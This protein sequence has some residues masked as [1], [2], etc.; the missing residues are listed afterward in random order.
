MIGSFRL[1]QS[2]TCLWIFLVLFLVVLVSTKALAQIP[3]TQ[4]LQAVL[5]SPDGALIAYSTGEDVCNPPVPASVFIVNAAT[6]NIVKT[7]P[8]GD[9]SILDLAWS[10]DSTRLAGASGDGLGFR[11]WDVDTGLMT[12]I[13]PSGGQG[14]LS[15]DWS[16]SSD[17]I[18]VTGLGGAGNLYNAITGEFIKALRVP[19]TNADWSPDG[20][21]I[22]SVRYSMNSVYVTDVE[23]DSLQMTLEGH[24]EP[25]VSIDWSP[26]GS[27][28]A[29]ASWDGTTRIW[30]ANSGQSL[31]IFN[32]SNPS[33]VRWNPNSRQVAVAS[34]DGFVQVW[35]VVTGQITD[36]YTNPG[37]VY[38]IAWSPDGTQ[39]AYG[40]VGFRGELTIVEPT[41][42]QPTPIYT[43][44]P[45]HTPT[46]TSTNT[47][48][49]TH[50]PDPYSYADARATDSD[51]YPNL[52]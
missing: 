45:T 48:T 24:S 15:V 18:F 22:A 30:D 35:D 16:P 49:P 17:E 29:S 13:A 3:Q 1:K 51:S 33:D 26:D 20:I 39:L 47:H 31:A 23:N 37:R 21:Q 5:W 43:P 8:I 44:T 38:A 19:A 10:S 9:C 42:I 50:T 27:K 4:Y 2:Q 40:G 14:N 7:L 34:F 11:V 46:F 12:A 36:T 41:I 28:L 6:G 52:R 32:I 25:V